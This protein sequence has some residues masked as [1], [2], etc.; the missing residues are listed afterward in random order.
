MNRWLALALLITAIG[1]AACGDDDADDATTAA[2]EAGLAEAGDPILIE[3]D[4]HIPVGEVLPGSHIGDSEFCPGG[5]FRDRPGGPGLGTIVKAFRC[6]DGDLEI[7]FSP[8]EC[9]PGQG[10]CREQSGPWRIVNGSA[11]FEGLRGRGRMTVE[12]ESR[13]SRDGRETF[14][15]SV[16]P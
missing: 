13:S 16:S 3:T 4:L 15:G 5:T 11:Q 8:G 1:V 12:F 2:D 9:G 14:T 10:E 6:P 7:T